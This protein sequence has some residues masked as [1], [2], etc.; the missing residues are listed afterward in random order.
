MGRSESPE[1]SR[2]TAFW[3]VSEALGCI[4]RVCSLRVI[5]NAIEC[6]TVFMKI[7]C[8]ETDMR[9]FPV[10][11]VLLSFNR[12]NFVQQAVAGALAQTYS[13]L[14]IL[15][16]D[17]AS[18]DR[19]AALVQEMLRQYTGPHTVRFNRNSLNLGL[20]AHLAKAADMARGEIILMANDDDIPHPSRV[21][22][23]M[24]AY[25]ADPRVMAVFSDGIHTKNGARQYWKPYPAAQEA[26]IPLLTLACRGGGVGRGATYSYRRCCFEEPSPFPGHLQIEDKILPLRAA[27][28]GCVAY[29][30]E[31]L[32][33]SRM[34]ADNM[35]GQK[36]YRPA[37]MRPEHQQELGREIGLFR[38]Q[39]KIGWWKGGLLTF[40]FRTNPA[41]WELRRALEGSG[42]RARHRRWLRMTYQS[43]RLVLR[44]LIEKIIQ[45]GA[46]R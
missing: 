20:G 40:I 11:M 18:T 3:V 21:A 38:T 26:R 45:R 29:L 35:S 36:G 2:R 5:D 8:V 41:Y 28:L 1:S 12:E 9:S 16:S 31:P 24:A 46:P 7:S 6:R 32:V 27:I 19:T 33:E 42:S 43:P 39:G 17:D 4:R 15:I 10:T 30:P 22:R 34:D 44:H 37:R 13:P 14:E 25:A 23:H